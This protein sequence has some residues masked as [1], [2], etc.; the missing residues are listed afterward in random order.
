[1]ELPVVTSDISGIR[2]LVEPGHTG[3]LCR[4]SDVD[5][6]REKI[7]MLLSD[8][9]LRRKLGQHGRQA[10]V[11]SFSVVA[12]GRKLPLEIE[13]MQRAFTSFMVGRAATSLS[14]SCVSLPATQPHPDH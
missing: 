6:M 3:L 14:G 2:E 4:A 5:D 8:V 13:R 1:M 12:E 7:E 9:Q 10:V 11:A